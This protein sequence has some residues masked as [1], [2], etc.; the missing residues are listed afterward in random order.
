M[1]VRHRA[2]PLETCRDLDAMIVPAEKWAREVLQLAGLKL[3]GVPNGTDDTSENYAQRFLSYGESIRKKIKRGDYEDA[4]IDAL[5]LGG[6]IRESQ[7]K[8]KWE[9]HVD[10]YD[11]VKA[12]AKAK[13]TLG[14]EA[15]W[16]G[17]DRDNLDEILSRLAVRKFYGDYLL[18]SDL[19]PILLGDLDVAGANPV[20]KNGNSLMSAYVIYGNDRNEFTYAA[21]RKQISRIRERV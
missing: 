2:A 18:P 16:G 12:A 11:E 20:E 14:A 4:V 13:G 5:I 8:N 6:F 7:L 17:E 19:W 21:F 3:D 9:T 1:T 15:R 10:K